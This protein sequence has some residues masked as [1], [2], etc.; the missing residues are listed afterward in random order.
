MK[1]AHTM[2]PNIWYHSEARQGGEVRSVVL[3]QISAAPTPI[4]NSN[5]GKLSCVL[6]EVHPRG[7]LSWGNP[8]SLGPYLHADHRCPPIG[9]EL[10][11]A[12]ADL[13]QQKP[14]PEQVIW[15]S[16]CARDSHA[17]L[18]AYQIA[19]ETR[20]HFLVGLV[21]TLCCGKR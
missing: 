9:K 1:F 19:F 14:P 2:V 13:T 7:K 18:S 17:K 8:E 10:S 11:A 20:P 16:D 15:N 21:W 5:A 3:G 6:L 12:S 4:S